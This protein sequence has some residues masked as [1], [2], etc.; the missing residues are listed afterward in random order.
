MKRDQVWTR[1]NEIILSWFEAALIALLKPRF[2]SRGRRRC[3]KVML[4]GTIR[5]DDF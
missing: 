3:L 2:R 1:E 4:H 5:N